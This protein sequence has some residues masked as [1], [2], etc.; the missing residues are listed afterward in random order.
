MIETI[1]NVPGLD[2]S[3]SH[4]A[5]K[6]EAINAL[7]V[8]RDNAIKDGGI[9]YLISKNDRLNSDI[10]LRERFASHSQSRSVKRSATR[11]SQASVRKTSTVD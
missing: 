7:A 1:D 4:A 9:Y 10:L 8:R 6:Q 11:L 3:T 2:Q 5:E